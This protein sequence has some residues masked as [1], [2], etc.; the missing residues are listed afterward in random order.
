MGI[1]S[2]KSSAPSSEPAP[3]FTKSMDP[4]YEGEQQDATSFRPLHMLNGDW[5]EGDGIQA[6]G[7]TTRYFDAGERERAKISVTA[8]GRLQDA[9][10]RLNTIGNSGNGTRLGEGADKNI[11][12]MTPQGE[13][14]SAPAWESRTTTP[15]AS[16]S[17]PDQDQIVNMVNHSSLAAQRAWGGGLESG[18]VAAAGELRVDDGKLQQISDASGHYR[19]TAEMTHQAIQALQGEQVDGWKQKRRGFLGLKKGWVEDRKAPPANAG[20]DMH[21]VELKLTGK[22]EDEK[23]LY[24]SVREF[25]ALGG[26]SGAE[27]L[28]R[29]RRAMM[30]DDI[31]KAARRFP[32]RDVVPTPEEEQAE[33]E[34]EARRKDQ[35]AAR[36]A[37]AAA[38]KAAAAMPEREASGDPYTFEDPLT[39]ATEDDAYGISAADSTDA[40][41]DAPYATKILAPPRAPAASSP[42]AAK[43]SVE[44]ERKVVPRSRAQETAAAEPFAGLY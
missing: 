23:N 40:A 12:V 44:P 22:A 39:G 43:V 33:A 19:P 29:D 17:N 6:T 35:A 34:E 9:N 38:R 21:D 5:K 13:L 26:N 42:Y 27:R 8:D 20:V 11:F 7:A 10:G 2:K 25:E 31:K 36:R 37:G 32:Q 18:K 28:M 1:F 24:A 41:S 15:D 3:L 4:K 16:S 30:K 14:R